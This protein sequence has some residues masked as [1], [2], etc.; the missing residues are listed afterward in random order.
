MEGYTLPFAYRSNIE[1]QAALLPEFGHSLADSPGEAND[2]NYGQA[3][4]EPVLC[5][6]KNQKGTADSQKE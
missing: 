3:E 1:H 6:V 4:K 5:K 2:E